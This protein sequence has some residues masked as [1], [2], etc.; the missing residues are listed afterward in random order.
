MPARCAHHRKLTLGYSDAIADAAERAKRGERQRQCPTCRLWLWPDEFGE[1]TATR[2]AVRT[3]HERAAY[4]A[5]AWLERRTQPGLHARKT[6]E[7]LLTAMGQ[8]L[9]TTPGDCEARRNIIAFG[10]EVL[11]P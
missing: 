11:R 8:V 7:Q 9:G 6:L 2:V 1:A 10:W 4:L 3:D 5:R